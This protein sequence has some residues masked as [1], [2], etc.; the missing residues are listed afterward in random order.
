M[1]DLGFKLYITACLGLLASFL[2]MQCEG[3]SVYSDLFK[4]VVSSL[5]RASFVFIVIGFL[6]MIWL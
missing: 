6:M 3:K 1:G 5:Q 2:V 4:A